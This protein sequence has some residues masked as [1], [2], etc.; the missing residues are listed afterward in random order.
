[1]S[2]D[3]PATFVTDVV[4][5]AAPIPGDAPGGV[6]IRNEPLFAQLREAR[7]ADDATVPRGVWQTELKRADWSLA[8]RLAREI[9]ETRSKDLLVAAWLMEAW[10]HLHGAAGAAEGLRVLHALC[11]DLWDDLHPS[12]EEDDPEVRDGVFHWINERVS[13]TLASVR[14]SAPQASDAQPY[15]WNDWRDSLRR[16]ETPR[17]EETRGRNAP[18]ADPADPAKPTRARVS[19]SVTL[20]PRPFYE[21]LVLELERVTDACARLRA[22][23]DARQGRDAPTLARLA[24]T[25]AAMR[26]WT[27]QVLADKPA[28][29]EN[30]G[31]PR[32]EPQTPEPTMDIEI[33]E[34]EPRAR[35]AIATRDEAYRQLRE[36][37]DYLMRTEPHSPT[38]FLVN[39]AVA[40]G[41]MSLGD[42]LME[43][44]RD[45]YDL[46]TLRSLLGM[47]ESAGNG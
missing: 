36:A 22:T 15:S 2:R 26:D 5:L 20:T 43:F 46:K 14:I 24:D 17:P 40:W 3:T 1:M 18:P 35:R 13:W 12:L 6:A 16:E 8:E 39:R 7:R 47:N 42:L 11:E 4:R 37:A 32:P 34:G 44:A 31:A 33:S 30:G 45:G 25:A 23:L 19:A 38:P 21:A 9:L 28:I 41:G 27:Q 10:I 29:Q